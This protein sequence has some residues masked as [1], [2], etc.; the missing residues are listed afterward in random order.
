MS[1]EE[2][3][4]LVEEMTAAREAMNVHRDRLGELRRDARS[5]G[6]D[7]QALNSLVDI[8]GENSHDR[9]KQALADLV[10]YARAVGLDSGLAAAPARPMAETSR[11][12]QGGESAFVV[13]AEPK[14]PLVGGGAAKKTPWSGAWV[15]GLLQGGLAITVSA[16]LLWL[17]H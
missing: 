7:M 12:G 6:L 14:A 9:G 5:G 1:G 11:L 4:K 15:K 16:A 2:L 13:P 10:F 8:M 3:R 17:L